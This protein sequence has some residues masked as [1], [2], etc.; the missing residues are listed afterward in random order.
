MNILKI[1][2]KQIIYRKI[3]QRNNTLYN[4]I[5]LIKIDINCQ[6]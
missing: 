1:E 6:V 2:I 3:A 5:S 4:N